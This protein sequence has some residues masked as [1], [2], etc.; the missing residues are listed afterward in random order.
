M[1]QSLT[2][3]RTNSDSARQRDDTK[4]T[5]RCCDDT[6]CE[7]LQGV[8]KPRQQRSARTIKQLGYLENG[9]GSHQSNQVIDENGLATC[10]YAGQYK[11]PL[12]FIHRK[13]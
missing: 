9:T 7:G 11:N 2:N 8:G 1:T 12:K 3:E 13:N 10:L 5:N 4:E 6:I